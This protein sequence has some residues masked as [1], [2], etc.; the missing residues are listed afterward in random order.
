[1][2]IAMLVDGLQESEK[3][4]ALKTLSDIIQLECYQEITRNN[5]GNMAKRVGRMLIACVIL[6]NVFQLGWKCLEVLAKG[7]G[8][9]GLVM[10]VLPIQIAIIYSLAH[11]NHWLIL[12]VFPRLED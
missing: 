11:S 2:T 1:M 5:L 7:S 9:F 10:I 3:F 4:F 12:L 8:A 6:V